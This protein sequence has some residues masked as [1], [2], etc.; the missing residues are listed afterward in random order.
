MKFTKAPDYVRE[1]AGKA[2]M[3]S[4]YI[5]KKWIHTFKGHEKGVQRV[6]FFP[7]YGHLMLS[8]SHDGSCK[9]WDVMNSR[10]CIRT[11]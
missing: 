6:R 4:N 3:Q 7:R 1:Q 10:K 5:P 2:H 9:I 8:A 11:Y